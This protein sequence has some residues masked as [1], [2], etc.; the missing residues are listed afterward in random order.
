VEAAE[1]WRERNLIMLFASNPN[2]DFKAG[3]S[4][5]SGRS[6]DVRSAD[7]SDDDD[8]SLACNIDRAGAGTVGWIHRADGSFGHLAAL[9]VFHGYTRTLK[10]HGNEITYSSGNLW[11]LPAEWW[12]DGARITASRWS[13]ARPVRSAS[14]LSQRRKDRT[15]GR[16]RSSV[17]SSP[18][19]PHLGST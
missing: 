18:G 11:R 17:T 2:P 9:I 5:L 19:R 10:E 15:V 4:A 8:W 6:Y 3:W 7:Y 13:G 14:P 16:R 12:I 1:L